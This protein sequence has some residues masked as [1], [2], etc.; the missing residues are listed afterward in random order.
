MIIAQCKEGLHQ[1][2][3]Q[4]LEEQRPAEE[5][6]HRWLQERKNHRNSLIAK[7]HAQTCDPNLHLEAHQVASIENMLPHMLVENQ[8]HE[9]HDEE[10][11][12]DL[13]A[14]RDALSHLRD[15]QGTNPG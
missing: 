9:H 6:L 14:L 3:M 15:G 11:L 7:V 2:Q 10:E 1:E 5:Q 12:Q 13:H 8:Q 4:H